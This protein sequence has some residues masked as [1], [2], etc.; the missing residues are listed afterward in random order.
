MHWIPQELIPEDSLV[1]LKDVKRNKKT[2]KVIRTKGKT[3]KFKIPVDSS[4]EVV[5]YRSNLHKINQQLV[6]HC[7]SI[8]LTNINLEAMEVELAEKSEDLKKSF[9]DFTSVQLTRIFARGSMEK[10][11]RFYRGWWQGIPERH[12]PHIRI[13]GNKAT[14]ADFSG[15]APRIIYGQ[16]EYLFQSILHL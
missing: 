13:D 1:E 6:R 5:Q 14:E 7:I 15:V 9:I 12:R 2:G 10:G 3:T 11:G 4:A 8:E 16:A